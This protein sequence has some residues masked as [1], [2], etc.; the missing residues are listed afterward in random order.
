PTNQAISY[1]IEDSILLERLNSALDHPHADDLENCS[2]DELKLKYEAL[3]FDHR[4][5]LSVN[6]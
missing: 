3:K 2:L 1:P 6:Y 5:T 4:S